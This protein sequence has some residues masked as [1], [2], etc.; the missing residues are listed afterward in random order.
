MQILALQCW[1]L[2]E[3]SIVGE[4]SNTGND[5]NKRRERFFLNVVTFYEKNR[6]VVTTF[7]YWII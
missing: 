6:N 2:E 3:N 4:V 7:F 1:E 5:F